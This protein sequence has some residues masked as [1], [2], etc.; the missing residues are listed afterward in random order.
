MNIHVLVIR[1]E[2]LNSTG[3]K[4]LG[5]KRLYLVLEVHCSVLC[6]SSTISDSQNS[7]FS[8]AYLLVQYPGLVGMGKIV[9]RRTCHL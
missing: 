2:I 5:S 6:K 1:V 4:I 9:K 7:C 3:M 8:K